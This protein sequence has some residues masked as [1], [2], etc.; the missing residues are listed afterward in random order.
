MW[1][2]AS[3]SQNA[4]H[5]SDKRADEDVRQHAVVNPVPRESNDQVDV[6]HR[7]R[8]FCRMIALR[9]NRTTPWFHTKWDQY[10]RSRTSQLVTVQIHSMVS[11]DSWKNQD[12][13]CKRHT[14]AF[15]AS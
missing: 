5:C 3:A 13:P 10:Q 11:L 14:V 12:R 4:F 1:P 6:L 2:A 8:S 7:P 15:S 9:T